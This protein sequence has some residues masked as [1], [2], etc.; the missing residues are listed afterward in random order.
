MKMKRR[1]HACR[2]KLSRKA[3]ADEEAGDLKAVQVVAS[4][5]SAECP[6]VQSVRVHV[7]VVR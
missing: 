2:Q 5:K 4:N 7:K 1:L 3:G 6:A